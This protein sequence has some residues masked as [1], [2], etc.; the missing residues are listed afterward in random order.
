MAR[1]SRM[2]KTLATASAVAVV[3]GIGLFN[4]FSAQ[5][6]AS[7]T[8][9]R[10][11]IGADYDSEL[12]AGSVNGADWGIDQSLH[13]IASSALHDTD[14]TVAGGA[15]DAENVCAGTARQP[16]APPG[17]VCIYPLQ[18]DN[19][20]NLTGYSIAPGTGGSRFGFKLL[21]DASGNGDT[22]VDAT[23]AYRFP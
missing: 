12:P 5:A 10:G 21:W 17:T 15:D 8:T 7:G 22:F 20:V 2:K 1:I 14:V 19:T 23:W 13:P 11:A 4:A 3:L 9:L 18:S 16:T 6:V